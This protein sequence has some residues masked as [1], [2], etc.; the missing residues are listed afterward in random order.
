MLI[1]VW[2]IP[3]P[4]HAGSRGG[5]GTRRTFFFSGAGE[6]SRH[7]FLLLALVFLAVI[8][9][10]AAAQADDGAVPTIT[11]TVPAKA[12]WL[13][14]WLEPADETKYDYCDDEYWF[15]GANYLKGK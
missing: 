11:F 9:P 3:R 5:L 13:G 12:V 2:G 15:R 1:R 14:Q 6:R 8:A 10:A 4:L 7:G